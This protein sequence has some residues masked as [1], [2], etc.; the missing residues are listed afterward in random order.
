M[1][2][3]DSAGDYAS[4]RTGSQLALMTSSR[5]H[6][7]TNMRLSDEDEYEEDECDYAT[8][9]TSSRLL[10]RDLSSYD[11]YT[12]CDFRSLS[13]AT[14]DNCSERNPLRYCASSRR[15]EALGSRSNDVHLDSFVTGEWKFVERLCIETISIHFLPTM[16][17]FSF[18]P[19]DT[20]LC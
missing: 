12:T 16:L 1:L 19:Y 3:F 2:D 8:A 9:L 20:D 13:H 6:L 11:G 5:S 17:F 18:V 4:S 14:E 7:A 10:G 15:P